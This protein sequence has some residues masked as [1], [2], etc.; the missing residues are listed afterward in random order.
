MIQDLNLYLNLQGRGLVTSPNDSTSPALFFMQGD[1]YRLVLNGLLPVLDN[2]L[3]LFAPAHIEWSRL[4]AGITLIDAAPTGG[5]FKVRAGLIDSDAT[6]TTALNFNISKGELQAALNAI[7]VIIAAGGI[8]VVSSGAANIYRLNWRVPANALALAVVENALS[9]LTLN[10]V[11]VDPDVAGKVELKLYQAPVTLTDQFTLPTAPAITITRVRSGSTLRNEVQRITVPDAAIGSFAL[12]W[13]DVAGSIIPVTTVTAAAVEAAINDPFYALS[14]TDQRFS[15]TSPATGIFDLE[16]VGAYAQTSGLALI[17]IEMFDQVPIDTPV[18]IMSLD[19]QAIEDFLD[20][21]A[22][23]RAIFEIRAY[24]S[25]GNKTMLAHLPVTIINDG[26]DDEVSSQI[27]TIATRV[28]TV[29]VYPDPSDS[30]AQAAAIARLGTSFTNPVLAQD[31]VFTHDFATMGVD[32]CVLIKTAGT[33]DTWSILPDDQYEV[34]ILND[35]QVQLFFGAPIPAAPAVGSVQV[36]ICTL[37]ATPIINDHRHSTDAIDG[38]GPDLGSTLTAIIATLRA[39]MPTGWP[40]IPANKIVGQL[41]GAQIDLTTLSTLLATN[42]SFATVFRALSNDSTVIAN[43]ANSFATSSDF[44]TTLSTLLGN[45]SVLNSFVTQL[46]S[47]PDALTA[48]MTTLGPSSG[49]VA[50][51]KLAVASMQIPGAMTL[52]IAPLSEILFTAQTDPAKLAGRGPYLLPQVILVGDPV[53]TAVIPALAANT[54]WMNNSG[55]A[56]LLPGGSGIRSGS[57]AA[58]SFFA[59]DGR[60]NYPASQRLGTSSFFPAPFERELWRLWIDDKMLPAGKTLSVQFAIALQ[61]INA[62][63]GAQ[64]VLVIEKGTADP[65]Q[66]VAFGMVGGFIHAPANFFVVGQ[67]VEFLSLTGGVGLAVATPYFVVAIGG[68]PSQFK[69]SATFGGEVIIF[70]TDITAAEMVM[71]PA[72]SPETLSGI[73]WDTANPLVKQRLI[74]TQNLITHPFGAIIFRGAD[75][76]GVQSLTAQGIYYSAA[77]T[78]P[79]APVSAN[80]LLR[81]RL[82]EFD[83]ENSVPL[84]RGWVSYALVPNSL[85]QLG[86]Q[87]A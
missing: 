80:F 86:A 78:A 14:S 46:G 32:V 8:D 10:R 75:V 58:G 45:S 2:S 1:T 77:Y 71:M 63:S 36:W 70:T 72:P 24:D 68:T 44:V 83:T 33:P 20:G 49:F 35:S 12:D 17:G 42:S 53:P 79:V 5:T 54:V 69:L 76:A 43:I 37:A 31:F 64:Y 66:I 13:L 74:L 55:A 26:I 51:V 21:A 65:E 16:F 57:V 39:A 22:S 62:D 60:I 48:L 61:L 23:G 82:I 73:T 15:V 6:T 47:S 81:A 18:G 50:A 85:A 19:N 4:S 30:A 67:S 9:P 59:S 11:A 29:Y 38:V 27:G 7:A 34:D 40:N 52:P 56:L 25:N 87:I 41:P 84:A 28:D 3:T